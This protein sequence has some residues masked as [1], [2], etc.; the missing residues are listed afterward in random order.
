MQAYTCQ[1][2]LVY[3]FVPYWQECGISRHLDPESKPQLLN[4]QAATT[5]GH[6]TPGN[7]SRLHEPTCNS[8][9]RSM[10]PWQHFRRIPLWGAFREINFQKDHFKCTAECS[11]AIFAMLRP[12]TFAET[13]LAYFWGSFH[14]IKSLTSSLSMETRS[15][16]LYA[17]C[18][19]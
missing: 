6:C 17:V 3:Q 10:V 9:A 8:S 19:S 2:C 15:C 13:E 16:W 1:W 5:N 12:L 11:F 18:F 14:A 4:C 7:I